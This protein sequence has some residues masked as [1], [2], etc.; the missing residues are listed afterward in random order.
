MN[1][2]LTSTETAIKLLM[3]END[4]EKEL[5]NA[6]AFQE[7][8]FWGKPRFGHPE[9]EVLYH[10][11]EVLN[12]VDKLELSPCERA[13][14]RLITFIHDTF[15]NIEAKTRRQKG[16]R[17]HHAFLA[18]E[19][20]SR[21]TDDRTVLNIVETHDDAFYAWRDIYIYMRPLRGR[22]RLKKL[23]EMI[24]DDIQLYYLFFKC[25]TQTGDKVQAPV[26]WFERTVK[27]IDVVELS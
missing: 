17:I 14:L 25:D 13:K 20:L 24:G 18:R 2:V 7:G 16:G 6:P 10:I 8:L 26:E 5:L 3:P 1:R 12:N 4:L 22:N 23:L 21:Y 27:G 9:G 11:R 19:F 15:K